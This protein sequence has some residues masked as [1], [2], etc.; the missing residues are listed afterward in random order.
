MEILLPSGDIVFTSG[1]TAKSGDWGKEANKVH[2]EFSLYGEPGGLNVGDLSLSARSD[3]SPYGQ[4]WSDVRSP[5]TLGN[6]YR[7]TITEL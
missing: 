7:V 1:A 5:F 2:V 6:L 4:G 3:A